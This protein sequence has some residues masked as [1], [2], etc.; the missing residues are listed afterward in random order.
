MC[1]ILFLE[2]KFVLSE[3]LVQQHHFEILC[4]FH[5]RCSPLCIYSY[6]TPFFDTQ[7][8]CNVNNDPHPSFGIPDIHN[9][10][11]VRR[12]SFGSAG[13]H[14]ENSG[15]HP[16]F[17]TQDIYSGCSAYHPFSFPFYLSPLLVSFGI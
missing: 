8:M 4:M 16:F 15:R 6:V 14:S 9:V 2:S 13:T 10:N 17:G 12:P 11:N 3:R 7:D 1:E 5:H